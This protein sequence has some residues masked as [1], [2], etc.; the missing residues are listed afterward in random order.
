MSFTQGPSLGF[1]AAINRIEEKD[2]RAYLAHTIKLNRGYFSN[3]I[4]ADYFKGRVAGTL[5]TLDVSP[6]TWNQVQRI[7]G[8]G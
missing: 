5:I 1:Y 8:R 3:P 6:Q 2:K 7:L 4:H